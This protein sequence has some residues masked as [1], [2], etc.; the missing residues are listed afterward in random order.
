[1]SSVSA[2]EAPRSSTATLGVTHR[3]V[4]CYRATEAV[5]MA[6]IPTTCKRLLAA[7]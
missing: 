6:T 2:V 4:P 3:V 7:R 5:T 1:M